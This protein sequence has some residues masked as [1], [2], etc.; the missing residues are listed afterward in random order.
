M[1]TDCGDRNLYI[2]CF[3]ILS[4]IYV[5]AFVEKQSCAFII[6]ILLYPFMSS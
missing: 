2:K 5:Y 4:A 3:V 6:Y 1:F